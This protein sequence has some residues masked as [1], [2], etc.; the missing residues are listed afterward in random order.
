VTDRLTLHHIDFTAP[1]GVFPEERVHGMAYRAD[2]T[3]FMDTSVP[4]HSDKL[5]DAVNY[6]E[7]ARQV[8][9]VA[10]GE[11]RM[12]VERLAEDISRRLLERFPVAALELSVTKLAPPVPEIGGG[13]T[14]TISRQ[15][16]RPRG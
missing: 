3:L 11:P 8:V 10:S 6:A 9:E 13:V 5:E 7:V 14:V 1:C 2:V 15:N 4:G 12:L 16:T